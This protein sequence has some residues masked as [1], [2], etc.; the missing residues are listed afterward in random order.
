MGNVEVMAAL[1]DT[2][3]WTDLESIGF[4]QL[5]QLI[6]TIPAPTMRAHAGVLVQ[7]ARAAEAHRPALRRAW[8]EQLEQL[9]QSAP[10]A[11]L[12]GVDPL[13]RRAGDAERARDLVRSVRLDDAIALAESVV[14]AAAPNELV[15]LG[16]AKLAIAHANAFTSSDESYATAERRFEEAAELFGLAGEHRLQAEA[17]ARL[18]YNVLFHQGKPAA[19]AAKL[20]L[21]VALLPSGDRTRAS[22]LTS[23]ADVL[24]WL[25]QTAESDAAVTEAIEIGERLRDNSVLGL[26][27]WTR[28]WSMGRRGDLPGL[29][30]AMREVE[31]LRPGWLDQANGVE[32]WGSLADQFIALGDT[33][34][35]Q[36]CRTKAEELGARVGYPQ[37]VAMMTARIDALSGDE[38]AT[39]AAL[40]TLAE[41]DRSVGA[42]VNTRWV[43]RLE[44]AVASLRLG[45][46]D[47]ARSYAAASIALC[48]EMGL[49]DLA[50]RFE[51]PLV[52]QL[53]PVWPA[54]QGD[55][56]PDA[57]TI[58]MLGTFA[59]RTGHHD[60]TPPAGHPSTLLK[61]LV[62]RKTMT[63]DAVIDA[64]WPDADIDTGRSRLRNTMNRLRTRSGALI[65]RRGETLELVS[66]ARADTDVFERAAADA[67]AA[68]PSMRIG[69]GRQAIALYTGELLPGDTFEDWAAAPRER[70]L[71]RYLS[72]I[73]MVAEAAQADGNHDEAARL[74][75]LGIAADALDERRYIRLADLLLSQGRANAA[76]QVA[77]RGLAVFAELGLP[78]G[79]ELLRLRG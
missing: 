69:L 26:A 30:T 46:L 42:A 72:L 55:T 24:D 62:L 18:G 63:T 36:H 38:A 74:L 2:R 70:M 7:A 13:V 33:E 35:L 1:L 21:A 52:Q 75:D 77:E 54:E 37:A 20:E 44:A 51:L 64:L 5:S 23:Y 43:R 11:Q 50:R 67:I 31:R 47:A 73:D 12:D 8:L 27:H 15:T 25:G 58:T 14:A 28:A 65:E 16:R 17:L 9:A 29:R 4:T 59:V 61:L 41:L 57:T 56:V 66:T 76:R 79:T 3:H 60:V 34:S 10:R 6:D 32:F 53:A 68:D 45:E 39:R 78:P 48:E 40:V 49:P 71:R 22:W 19:S